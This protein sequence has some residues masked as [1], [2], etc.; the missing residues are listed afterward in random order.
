MLNSGHECSQGD[1]SAFA[2]VLHRQ[3]RS[4]LLVKNTNKGEGAIKFRFKNYNEK[5]KNKLDELYKKYHKPP[6]LGCFF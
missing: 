5:F 1:T 4:I 2:G 6:V 3:L